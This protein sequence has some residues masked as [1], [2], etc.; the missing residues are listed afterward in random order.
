MGVYRDALRIVLGICKSDYDEYVDGASCVGNVEE[1]VRDEVGVEGGDDYISKMVEEERNGQ[2]EK[3]SEQDNLMSVL[4]K[5]SD[6]GG[7]NG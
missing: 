5:A 3:L 1:A 4:L 6:S 7:R 2:S